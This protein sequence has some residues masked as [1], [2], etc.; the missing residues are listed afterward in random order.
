MLTMLKR[1]CPNCM[2][3]AFTNIRIIHF[4]RHRGKKTKNSWVCLAVQPNRWL[5]D[6]WQCN[7]MLAKDTLHFSASYLSFQPFPRI[8]WKVLLLI[9]T[10]LISSSLFFSVPS[11]CHLRGTVSSITPSIHIHTV[12]QGPCWVY[13]RP[14]IDSR[15]ISRG[16]RVFVFANERIGVVGFYADI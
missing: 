3:V 5:Q 8:T 13:K 15:Q 7:C 6:T 2:Y 9:L 14:L 12:S 16:T 1:K 4:S 11:F 10:L